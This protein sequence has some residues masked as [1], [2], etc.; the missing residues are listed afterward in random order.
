MYCNYIYFHTQLYIMAISR[1]GSL[2]RFE[3][4]TIAAKPSR[5]PPA[6]KRHAA[7]CSAAPDAAVTKQNATKCPVAKVS[8]FF[9]D[10]ATSI[11]GANGAN[12]HSWLSAGMSGQDV[13]GRLVSGLRPLGDTQNEFLVITDAHPEELLLKAKALDNRRNQVFVAEPDSLDAQYEALELVLDALDGMDRL[14]R[15]GSTVR[16]RVGDTWRSWDMEAYKEC[17]LELAA[18]MVQ[19]DL[20]IMRPP[21]DGEPARY[22]MAAACVVFSFG[23]LEAKLG[24]GMPLIHAPVPGFETDLDRL[25][26]KTFDKLRADKPGVPVC[27]NLCHKVRHTLFLCIVWRVNWGL[28]PSGVLDEPLYGT[29]SAAHPVEPCH[30]VHTQGLAA[31]LPAPC[32]WQNAT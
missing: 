27:C 1:G 7:R 15:D 6:P 21:R 4:T 5:N 31:A 30:A 19:E 29:A 2:C 25:L 13:P 26:T 24:A 8:N 17:P 14:Q 32:P 28:A 11:L 20:V 12:A 10:A 9:Q 16:V 18:R 22:A 3:K 23:E